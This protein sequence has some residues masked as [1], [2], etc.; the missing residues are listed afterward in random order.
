MLVHYCFV[1]RDLPLGII[2]AMLVHAAGES[3]AACQD[4]KGER[5]DG[6]TAVVLEARD[7]DHLL[8]IERYLDN[9]DPVGYIPI[10]ESE[11][12]YHGQFMAIGVY[13]GEREVLSP[14]M[15]Q[16]NILR[17]CK[18]ELDNYDDEC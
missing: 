13:P 8:E 15:K 9:Q 5:F 16:F 4:Y 6:G 7:E 17:E 2:G 11:G 14:I 10:H 1:R 3:A 12:T 18:T